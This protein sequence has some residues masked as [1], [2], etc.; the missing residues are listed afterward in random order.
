MLPP[1]TM[2]STGLLHHLH[3]LHLVLLLLLL[4]QPSPNGS[5]H[6]LH[7][8][9]RHGR[10]S[11]GKGGSWGKVRHCPTCPYFLN[12][13]REVTTPEGVPAN[14][15]CGV[16]NLFDRK[17]SWIRRR[18]LHVLT[19]GS[20]TY[21]SDSRFRALHLVGSPFW[22]LQVDSPRAHDSGV[23]ECQVSMQPKISRRFFLFVVI[24]SAEIHGTRQVYMKTGSD[25]NITCLVSGHL[26]DSPITWY[27]APLPVPP[28][29]PAVREIR[30]GGRGGVQLV[31]DKHAGTSW[32]LV[33][34]ATWRDAGNYTCAPRHAR[35]AS[36]AIH[37][38]DESPAA[39]QHDSS[40]A[41]SPFLPSCLLLLL[42]LVLHWTTTLNTTTISTKQAWQYSE[43]VVVWVFLS[44]LLLLL[45]LSSSS[46]HQ[47]EPLVG[48]LHKL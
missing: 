18:D 20:Y 8:N 21:T 40:S 26:R 37:V 38:V 23:Y 24:P 5:A 46:C 1:S 47:Q 22:T 2:L 16:K 48:Q 39:M 43:R 3:L 28:E 7:H 25:I 44:P 14:L 17:V 27:H 13:T 31:T 4:T 41:A 42:L 6:R 15:T 30:T 11:W 45:L 19:A 32:L 9:H 35:P 12:T 36:V 29:K 34:H 33:K 10:G